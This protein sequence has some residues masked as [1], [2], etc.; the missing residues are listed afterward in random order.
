MDSQIDRRSLLK[1][2]AMLGVA[3]AAA[4]AAS[5]AEP[6]VEEGFVSLFD[7]LTLNGWGVEQG[8]ESAFYVEDGTITIHGG[9]TR[10]GW[11]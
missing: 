5:R 3:P 1:G 4:A 9:R 6:A 8:P 7:G 11:R 10:A 2:A